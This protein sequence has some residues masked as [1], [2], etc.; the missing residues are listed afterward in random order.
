[1]ACAHRRCPPDRPGSWSSARVPVGGWRAGGVKARRTRGPSGPGPR[2]S[3]Q[4]L[5]EVAQTLPKGATRPTVHNHGQ[6]PPTVEADCLWRLSSSA[7][8]EAS[9][10]DGVVGRGTTRVVADSETAP[11]TGYAPVNGLQMYY[12]LHGSGGIPLLLLHGGLFNIDLQFGQLMVG[13]L[14]HLDIAQ[15]DVFGFSV[16]ALS[17]STWPSTILSW[18]AS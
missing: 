18:S 14:G 1:M 12:E 7:P 11:Q 8:V 6:T 10:L 3:D 4:Q 5:A 17:P 2:L 16:G 15:A 13:L 9:T